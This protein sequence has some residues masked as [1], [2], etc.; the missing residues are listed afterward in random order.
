[1]LA[2]GDLSLTAIAVLAPHLT[3]DNHDAALNAARH[4]SKREVE[5]L[6]AEIHP[7]P[8]VPSS[9]RKL[10]APKPAALPASTD[11]PP[12]TAANAATPT[13]SPD[14]PER[15]P[16]PSKSAPMVAPL[17][18]E[19]YKIQVTVSRET[20]EKLRRAQ[21]LLR[22]TIPSGDPAAIL[23]RA[24]ALL[25]AEL[26]RGKL[27][28][29]DRPNRAPT[30]RAEQSRNI[31]AAVKRAVWTRDAGRCAFVGT[32][33]RCRETGFLEF[34]HVVPYARCGPAS[35]ANIELRCAAHNAHE[36]ALCFGPRQPALVRETGPPFVVA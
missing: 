12:G 3:Q 17:A 35:I 33:G 23:D 1:L 29:T 24:L 13:G 2:N 28:A 9:V 14:A 31:P 19:R 34:H 22:H 36:A 8:D 25:V 20:Y 7:R 11:A 21:D 16:L 6:A 30:R 10:P 26:E 18:P 4:K 27:A 5:R 15:R 32:N